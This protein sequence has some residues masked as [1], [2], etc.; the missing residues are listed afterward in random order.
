[1]KKG[2]FLYMLLLLSI[3]VVMAS[4]SQNVTDVRVS[5]VR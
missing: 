1:M 4:Y 3:T 5:N 2:S